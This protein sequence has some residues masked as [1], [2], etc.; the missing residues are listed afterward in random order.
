MN[1]RNAMIPTPAIDTGM[2]YFMRN[3]R[4][5]SLTPIPAG[6]KNAKKPINAENVCIPIIN[7][8]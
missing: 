1:K 8:R 4:I 3:N 5:P 2:T 7:T 6:A